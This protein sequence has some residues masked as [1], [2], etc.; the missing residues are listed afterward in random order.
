MRYRLVVL[1]HGDCVPLERTL[2]SF[3]EH[4]TPA[5]FDAVLVYDGPELYGAA[6]PAPNIGVV[7]TVWTIA[8]TPSRGGFCAATKRAWDL[9]SREVVPELD[10]D[11]V[12][13]L[14]HDFDFLRPVD[15]RDLAHVID[16]RATHLAQMALM[17]DAVN[18]DERDAGGL[19]QLRRAG[20][21]HVMDFVPGPSGANIDYLEHRLYFTTNP[22]LMRRDWMAAHPWPDYTSE[23]EGRFGLDLV[24]DG[25]SFGA[26]GNGEPWVGHAGVRDGFGY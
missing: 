19:Y 6:S 12:F 21:E 3:V 16:R 2:R 18:P 22:S 25:W 17:R 7:D 10:V 26:W 5:P 9:A 4:V 24:A 15:L 14:E 8:T 20:Y 1:T 11:H 13:W 23:C